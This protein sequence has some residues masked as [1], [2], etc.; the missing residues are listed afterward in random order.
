MPYCKVTVIFGNTVRLLSSYPSLQ[1]LL[2]FV[3]LTS[4]EDYASGTGR[5]AGCACHHFRTREMYTCIGKQTRS[6]FN[7]N[8]ERERE[9]AEAEIS[10][11]VEHLLLC[12]VLFNSLSRA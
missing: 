3:R 4:D 9:R 6:G 10:G 12:V 1:S 7:S 5:R 11:N 8:G 2:I